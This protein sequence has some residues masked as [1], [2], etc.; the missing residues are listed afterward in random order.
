MKIKFVCSLS[1]FAVANSF[2]Y[3]ADAQVFQSS[4]A[5]DLS[6]VSAFYQGDKGDFNC[7]AISVIK[8]TIATFGAGNVF[9]DV[10]KDVDGFRVTLRNSETVHLTQAEL[11]MAA[12]NSGFISSD[13]SG[14][15]E[16]ANLI[17]AVM[18]RRAVGFKDNV[19]KDTFASCT[20]FN[21]SL[22]F[23]HGE[24]GGVDAMTLPQLLGLKYEN[25]KPKRNLAYIHE[26]GYHAVFA[27]QRIFDDFGVPSK[28]NIFH[29][30]SHLG[31]N[32]KL[33]LES[34][35]FKIY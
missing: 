9:K 14:I 6:I 23:L 16:A 5:Y 20:S 31:I 4:Y 32:P 17:Y 3:I 33:D 19:N 15:T 1:I 13:K 27:S 22:F 21:T 10:I 11:K 2:A 18:V 25:V 34:I 30:K 24:T 7:A 26:N 29:F 8:C 12:D 35:N 28:L